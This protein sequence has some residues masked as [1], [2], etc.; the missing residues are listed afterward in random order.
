MS[1]KSK[2][3]IDGQGR[4]KALEYLKNQETKQNELPIKRNLSEDNRLGTT[5]IKNIVYDLYYG[6]GDDKNN[7]YIT[8]HGDNTKIYAVITEEIYNAIFN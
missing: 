2:F 6:L 5:T 7:Y 8:E 3:I 1:D 4:I